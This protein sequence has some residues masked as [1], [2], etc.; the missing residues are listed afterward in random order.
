MEILYFRCIAMI[1]NTSQFMDYLIGA[2]IA[3]FILVYLAYSLMRP[4][5]F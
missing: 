2:I 5:K 4:E 1:T 3:F